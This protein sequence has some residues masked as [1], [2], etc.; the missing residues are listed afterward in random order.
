MLLPPLLL[1][2]ATYRE[3][4]AAADDASALALAA[5]VGARVCQARSAAVGQWVA[6]QRLLAV[7]AAAAP[8]AGGAGARPAAVADAAAATALADT[9][10]REMATAAAV[11]AACPW[12]GG[13]D[14]DV[15]AS[16]RTD[17]DAL[18]AAALA[19]DSR[20][21]AAL[22]AAVAAALRAD[23]AT[24]DAHHAIAAAA[25]SNDATASAAAACGIDAVSFAALTTLSGLTNGC[26]QVLS[27]A[28]ASG[29][30]GILA[31]IAAGAIWGWPLQ[32]GEPSS[33][34]HASHWLP[35]SA[36][37]A[38][39]ATAPASSRASIDASM[40]ALAAAAAGDDAVADSGKAAVPAW[41]LGRNAAH[42]LAAG[43]DGVQTC[44]RRLASLEAVVAMAA[45]GS[46]APADRLETLISQ[47]GAE[48]GDSN[49][50]AMRAQLLRETRQTLEALAA[51]AAAVRAGSAAGADDASGSQPAP[52]AAAMASPH[53]LLIPLTCGHN[54]SW[55]LPERHLA[56]LAVRH[57]LREWQRQDASGGGSSSSS[58]G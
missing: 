40:I 47:P 7:A 22:P 52:L 57:M 15:A 46:G 51:W 44:L 3:P 54:T 48:N 33:V 18:A 8:A 28:L 42:L 4:A 23:S 2:A 29:E 25:I 38:A 37:A 5:S 24:A 39:A 31:C 21:W 12:P 13:I 43:E 50:P 16:L 11:A 35:D 9:V 20:A 41:Q 53:G 34:R 10:V 17:G 19:A 56:E 27:G 58:S 36:A 45:G 32:R 14:A 6:R 49:W 55:R 30:E 26:G 1:R